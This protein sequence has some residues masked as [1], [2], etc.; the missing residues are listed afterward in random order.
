M[1]E[2]YVLLKKSQAAWDQRDAK[3]MLDLARAA[4]A[5]DWTLPPHVAAEAAQQEAR[6]D[7]M[8][9]ANIAQ[10]QRRL[11]Q[12]QLSLARVDRDSAGTRTVAAHYDPSLLGIQRA[13]C[14]HE[15]GKPRMALNLYDEHLR[16][17]HFSE[18][19]FA[20][21]LSLSAH[22]LAASGEPD[23]AAQLGSKVLSTTARTNSIRTVREVLRLVD[24]L[25]P[26]GERPAVR[27]LREQMDLHRDLHESGRG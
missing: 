19:D 23:Q 13:I 24:K 14:Y 8:L 22:T 10:V 2:G 6:G 4:Q 5:G 16:D 11:D 18:R 27:E 9:G 21:F 15:A 20:Y 12:A 3:R 7:A 1:L 26:W 25:A 17:E